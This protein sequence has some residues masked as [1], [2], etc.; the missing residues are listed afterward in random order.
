[1]QG[2]KLPT[3]RDAE[4]HHIDVHMNNMHMCVHT[5]HACICNICDACGLIYT[6]VHLYVH[7]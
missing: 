7:V 2:G 4:P 1:M 5:R 6:H 3:W